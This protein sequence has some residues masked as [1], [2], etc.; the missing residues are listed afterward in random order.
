MGSRHKYLS[1]WKT[2]NDSFVYLGGPNTEGSWRFKI[3]GNDLVA[4]R[5]E[6]GSWVEKG[7]FTA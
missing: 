7:A 4:Q 6:S 1:S 5:L 2:D 3:D